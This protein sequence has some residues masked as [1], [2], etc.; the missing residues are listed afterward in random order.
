MLRSVSL[1][2]LVVFF[3]FADQAIM[4]TAGVPGDMC[5]LL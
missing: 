5:A 4:K 2:N 1:K 3:W